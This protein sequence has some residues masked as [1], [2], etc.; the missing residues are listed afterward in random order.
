VR[1]APGRVVLAIGKERTRI[2]LPEAALDLSALRVVIEQ[3]IRASPRL[4]I[5]AR[6]IA[7]RG[8]RRPGERRITPRKTGEVLPPPAL[9]WQATLI[10]VA[11]QP[12]LQV[13]P[14]VGPFAGEDA[15][16][17]HVA[18]RTVAAR[19]EVPQHAVLPRAQCLDG[20]L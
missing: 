16:H 15:V 4:G 20:A 9:R 18:R 12:V 8:C 13:P 1:R 10:A 19:A 3:V 2:G 14:H 17:D 5:G 7:A 11:L 6:K